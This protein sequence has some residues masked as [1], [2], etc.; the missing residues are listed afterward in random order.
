MNDL[1]PPWRAI[2]RL[3]G[4][5]VI[6]SLGISSS[7]QADIPITPERAAI[8]WFKDTGTDPGFDLIALTSPEFAA[9]P[10]INRDAIRQSIEEELQTAF[11]AADV[12]DDIYTIRINTRLSE[13]DPRAGGFFLALFSGN[14]YIPLQLR[15]NRNARG[16]FNGQYELHFLNNP[17]F[18]FWPTNQET[19]QGLMASAGREPRA[20]VEFRVQPIAG[21]VVP[22]ATDVAR[23]IWGRVLEARV[24][25]GT[26]VPFSRQVEPVAPADM[27]LAR[28]QALDIITNPDDLT[29]GMLWH[30]IVGGP[31]PD[32]AAMV[33]NSESLRR[34]DVF[35]RDAVEAALIADARAYYDR[36]DPNKALRLTLNADVGPYDVSKAEFP[37]SLGGAVRYNSSFPF[38]PYPDDA[39]RAAKRNAGKSFVVP[40]GS[41]FT[42][43]NMTFENGRELPGFAADQELARIVGLNLRGQAEIV[44]RPV[45]AEI[46]ENRSATD[47]VKI[48]HTR[49]EQIRV[50]DP[51][52]GKLLH[53]AAYPRFEGQIELRKTKPEAETFQ[54]VDPYTVEIR[55]LKLGMTEAEAVAVGE[56]VFGRVR[57]IEDSPALIRLFG[58]NGERAALY[59]DTDRNVKTINY[60]RT[61]S[62]DVAQP[63]MDAVLERYGRP[64]QM[65]EM[66]LDPMTRSDKEANFAWTTNASSI[67]GFTGRVWFWSSQKETKLY[68]DLE[69]R[70]RP[71]FEKADPVIS[72]D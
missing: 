62:D 65:T 2:A 10:E 43:F 38:V 29:M 23:R 67:G 48:L 24:E 3:L 18:F 11:A 50:V 30:K 31:E 13:F 37:I 12:S 21:Q 49:I 35:A 7:A 58:Q 56:E 9:A 47:E 40:D 54:G 45:A 25:I 8:Y 66:R 17:D 15:D 28:A 32:W 69:D 1:S 61:W 57:Y 34:A 51:R 71:T 20:V 39:E 72:L 70:R 5:F 64:A 60:V 27:S 4:V 59:L 46:K 19:A 53:R 26:Q 6:L 41:G 68:L 44:V 33:R 14:S 22:P 36:I 16:A 63:V 42:D 52:S 55:G